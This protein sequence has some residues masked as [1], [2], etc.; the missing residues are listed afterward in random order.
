MH[1]TIKNGIRTPVGACGLIMGSNTCSVLME[2]PQIGGF[3]EGQHEI[4]SPACSN[5]VS[6]LL[7]G[8]R[9]FEN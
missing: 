5:L 9:K 6:D 3:V 7:C 2:S 4:K 8:R 1:L